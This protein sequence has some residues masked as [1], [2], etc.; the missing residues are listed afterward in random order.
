MLR[1]LLVLFAASTSTTTWLANA[2]TTSL[3]GI[4]SLVQR[5]VPNHADKFTFSL[6][7][8]SSEENDLDSFVLSDADEGEGIDIQCTTVSACARGLYTYVDSRY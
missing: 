4:S 8:P 3:D 5:Q 7:E 6:I 2:A 1:L